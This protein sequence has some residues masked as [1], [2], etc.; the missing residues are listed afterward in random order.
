MKAWSLRGLLLCYVALRIYLA[1]L[2]GFV[3]DLVPYRDWALGSALVGM[4]RAYEK[5]RIDYPPL[6]LY[7][8]TPIGKAYLLSHPE[9]E[10]PELP[11]PRAISRNW[12]RLTAGEPAWQQSPWGEYFLQTADGTVYRSWPR[13]ALRS[14]PGEPP[15][16]KL[17]PHSRAFTVAVR[18]PFLLADLLLALLLGRAVTR[19]GSWRRV[20]AKAAGRIA[21]GAY[22]LSPAVLMGSAYWGQSDALHAV[23]AVAG[24]LAL[25]RDHPGRA[26]LL[27]ALSGWMKPLALPL[28]PLF[29]VLAVGRGGLRGLLRLAGGGVAATLLAFLPFLLAGRGVSA[30]A[31]VIQHLDAMPFTSVNAHNFWWLIG[32]WQKAV[33]VPEGGWSP[34]Q[35][36]LALVL[37]L[38]LGLL[39]ITFRRGR[40]APP[41]SPELFGRVFRLAAA[42]V[43]L[44]FFLSTHQHENHLFLAIPLLIFGAGRSRDQAALALGT[45]IAAAVNMLLHDPAFLEV[46]APESIA[47]LAPAPAWLAAART[48]NAWFVALLTVAMV[49]RAVWRDPARSGDEGPGA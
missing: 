14:L 33:E 43:A 20:G 38:S 40:A 36:S 16:A 5:T 24:C 45:G 30:L 28:L 3:G 6:V 18:L 39:A 27:L 42:L 22:L 9:L 37:V 25:A 26:G 13:T 7:L 8:F 15:D 49:L 34:T 46:T 2:P 31:R 17:L 44:F 19:F 41:A 11:G 10:V 47:S 21:A 35:R 4:P 48:S 32:S 29:V 1:S 12:C 23:L